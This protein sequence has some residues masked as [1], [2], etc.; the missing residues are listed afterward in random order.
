[1]PF[2]DHLINAQER[3]SEHCAAFVPVIVRSRT[4]FAPI[5]PVAYDCV[6]L[7]VVRSGSAIPISEFGR[8][9]VSVGDVVEFL[10]QRTRRLGHIH[11]SISI[12]TMWSIK[13]SGSTRHFYATDSTRR[14]SPMSCTQIPLRYCALARARQRCSC[15]GWTRCACNIRDSGP[16]YHGG[17]DCLP[18]VDEGVELVGGEVIEEAAADTCEVGAVGTAEQLDA[19]WGERCGESTGI[20]FSR[21]ALNQSAGFEGTNNP[22]ETA[23][24]L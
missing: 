3:R 14:T 1:M 16:V 8:K 15:R 17:V 10:W 11:D 12:V 7:I 20:T 21:C 9:P 2:T 18:G 5:A 23:S 4:I 13:C 19:L 24:R 6:K 22:G